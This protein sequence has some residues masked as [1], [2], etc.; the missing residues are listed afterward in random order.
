MERNDK[1]SNKS[2]KISQKSALK[3][4]TLRKSTISTAVGWYDTNIVQSLISVGK[5]ES[6][7]TL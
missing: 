3:V 5:V 2:H 6:K 1:S 4:K 7:I